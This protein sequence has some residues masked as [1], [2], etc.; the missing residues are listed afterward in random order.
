MFLNINLN[1][2]QN[3][4]DNLEGKVILK[5]VISLLV[6]LIKS[7]SNR[8]YVKGEDYGVIESD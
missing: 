3:D 6:G 2:N 7:N 8:V 1:H 4:A 5:D